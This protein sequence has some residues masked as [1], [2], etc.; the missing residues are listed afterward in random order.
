MTS[1]GCSSFLGLGGTRGGATEAQER[2]EG[3]EGPEGPEGPKAPD[4][5]RHGFNDPPTDESECEGL[6]G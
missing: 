3:Q 6:S 4:N 2:P 5:L 1:M